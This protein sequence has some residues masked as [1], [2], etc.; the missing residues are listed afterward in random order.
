MTKQP[1]AL[2]ATLVHQCRQAV[3]LILRTEAILMSQSIAVEGATAAL[4]SG[5]APHPPDPI[6]SAITA[7]A[8]ASHWTWGAL[9]SMF[10]WFFGA[11]GS[12]FHCFFGAM[13]SICQWMFYDFIV[14]HQ[15]LGSFGFLV[16]LCL[17]VFAVYGI[18]RN[19]LLT[20]LVR[21]FVQILD[22]WKLADREELQ[23]LFT[24]GPNVTFNPNM[25]F[26]QQD[27]QV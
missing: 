20:S 7:A 22:G 4:A 14:V 8:S 5:T 1:H 16:V 3:I 24:P 10:H 17:F 19:Q 18:K 11:M 27:Q 25:T 26:R 23:R 13:S 2:A 9:D 21:M 12:M 6:D 15:Y